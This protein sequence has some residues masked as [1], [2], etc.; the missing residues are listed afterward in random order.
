MI[1]RYKV[2]FCHGRTFK[3]SR[4]TGMLSSD[5]S[6]EFEYD[7]TTEDLDDCSSDDLDTSKRSRRRF[8]LT[9]GGCC[10]GIV[11]LCVAVVAMGANSFERPAFSVTEVRLSRVSITGLEGVTLADTSEC[12]AID[13]CGLTIARGCGSCPN[14]GDFNHGCMCYQ[15]SGGTPA[16][17]GTVVRANTSD[18]PIYD[19]CG[20]LV[21]KGC[22]RCP[23]DDPSWINQGCLCAQPLDPDQLRDRLGDI[24]DI[25]RGDD[26]NVSIEMNLKA[27]IDNPNLFRI[28]TE[29]GVMHLY[30]GEHEIGEASVPKVI[31]PPFSGQALASQIVVDGLSKDVNRGLLKSIVDNHG[32]INVTT[33]GAVV[34]NV[35]LW[36]VQSDIA[37]HVSQNVFAGRRDVGQHID[38]DCQYTVFG[39]EV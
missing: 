24:R 21:A 15:K 19:K 22:S 34:A 6:G 38:K 39:R 18:C 14:E 33:R 1:K 35:F 26:H 30:W 32:V 7:E 31:V 5:D 23:D 27:E 3:S 12:P 16:P 11:V 36:Q 10:A 29:P 8:C 4:Q 17:P 20:L 25:L 37:C 28:D 2:N 9:C 13:K